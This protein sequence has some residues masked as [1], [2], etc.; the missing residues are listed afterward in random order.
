MNSRHSV[1]D[2]DEIYGKIP[3]YLNGTLSGSDSL[4]VAA[5]LEVCDVCRD[6]A[7]VHEIIRTAVQKEELAPLIP[8][9]SAADIL[10]MDGETGKSQGSSPRCT[11][12]AD[13]ERSGL[14][15]AAAA[16]LIAITLVMT[17]YAGQNSIGSA[18]VFE[19]ATSATS[20]HVDYVMRVHFLAGVSTDE[21]ERVIRSLDEV[22]KWS[23][24]ERDVYELHLQLTETS[25]A[26]LEAYENHVRSLAGVQSAEVIALQLPVR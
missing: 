19:T 8:A 14:A 22:G 18:N 21:S 16:A 4:S 23:I 12:A 15:I 3:W 26:G 17:Y 25:L 2:H 24:D 1:T 11:P 6:E 13:R 9:S 7:R 10:A 5:H 20:G